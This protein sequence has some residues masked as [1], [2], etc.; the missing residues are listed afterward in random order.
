MNRKYFNGITDA[1]QIN[2]W[3]SVGDGRKLLVYIFVH[4]EA[5]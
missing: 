5:D 4:V 3:V 2:V 1:I